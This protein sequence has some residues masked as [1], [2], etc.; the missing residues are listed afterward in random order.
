ML[1]TQDSVIQSFNVHF[2]AVTATTWVTQ[3]RDSK[4][5]V[6]TWDFCGGMALDVGI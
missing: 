6:K 4:E 1:L 3:G 2:L 5:M